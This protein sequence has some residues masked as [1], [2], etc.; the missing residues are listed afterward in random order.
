MVQ[1]LRS[2][3]RGLFLET[4]ITYDVAA[5]MQ[6]SWILSKVKAE[7]GNLARKICLIVPQKR[8]AYK[9]AVIQKWLTNMRVSKK[10]LLRPEPIGIRQLGKALNCYKIVNNHLLYHV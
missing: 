2:G 6:Q 5:K 7:K 8:I 1:Q 3:R 10:R 9:A 4:R